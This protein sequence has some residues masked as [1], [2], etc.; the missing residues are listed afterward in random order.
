MGYCP[1]CT[2][3]CNT[4]MLIEEAMTQKLPQGIKEIDRSHHFIGVNK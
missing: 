4:S 1:V 2:E 3:S